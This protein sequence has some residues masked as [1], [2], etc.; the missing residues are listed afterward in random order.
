ML[1]YPK[2]LLRICLL[3]YCR[4]SF[5]EAIL[6]VILSF[7]CFFILSK[8]C[9]SSWGGLRFPFSRM[10]LKVDVSKLKSPPKWPLQIQIIRRFTHFPKRHNLLVRS[11]YTYT[12]SRSCGGGG[13]G[14][15]GRVEPIFAFRFPTTCYLWGA[16]FLNN[17]SKTQGITCLWFTRNK[18]FMFMK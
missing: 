16:L 15:L 1:R 17:C 2:F 12:G 6:G 11:R 8:E 5:R 7:R 14:V 9:I 3:A 4:D 10:S 18:L 13:E